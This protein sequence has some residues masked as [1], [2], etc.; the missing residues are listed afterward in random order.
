MGRLLR[1]T[2][3]LMGADR[4][5]WIFDGEQAASLEE[6]YDTWAAT[7]DTDHDSWGWRGPDLVAAATLRHI[8]AHEATATI[9][10]AGCGTGMAGIALRNAGWSGV[11][12]GLD[13]S[14]GMLDQAS[15]SG[16]YDALVKCSLYDIPLADGCVA[17]TVA[18]GVFT[19][20]HVGGE[21]LAELCRITR[22]GGIVTVTQRLDLAA[23]FEPHVDALRSVGD[24]V[25]IDRTTPEQLHPDRDATE[26]TVITWRV[27]PR[28]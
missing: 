14:Q 21:A 10:D 27:R 28:S 4:I 17:A 6:R 25:E 11:L 16:A 26:Q 2:P 3:A 15:K 9:V 24:W 8:G 20:G 22:P 19:L 1:V 18:S 7:Y 13:L 5:D 12:V 23:S